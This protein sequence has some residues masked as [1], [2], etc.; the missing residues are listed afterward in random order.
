[1]GF[2]NLHLC[3]GYEKNSVEVPSFIK[4]FSGKSFPENLFNLGLEIS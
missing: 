2:E 1:M 3:T 4:T